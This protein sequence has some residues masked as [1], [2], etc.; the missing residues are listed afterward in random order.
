MSESDEQRTQDESA[1]VEGH[2]MRVSD[3]DNRIAGEERSA[4]EDDGPDVEGHAKIA[5]KNRKK[6]R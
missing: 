3:M 5:K 2:T 6:N 1:D 4:S